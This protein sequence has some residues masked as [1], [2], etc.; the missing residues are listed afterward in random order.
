MRA[1]SLS[2]VIRRLEDL[3]DEMDFDD[4]LP[5]ALIRDV[6]NQALRDA[7]AFFCMDCEVNTSPSTGIGE[8]YMVTDHVWFSE[9]DADKGML[10]IGCLEGRINRQLEKRD[11]IDALINQGVFHMSDRFK[12]RVG[13][14]QHAD[15]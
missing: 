10:C 5:E 7:F 4:K 13:G 12:S 15:L 2:D 9:A 6:I 8:Y 1:V 3:E 11:F 14:M